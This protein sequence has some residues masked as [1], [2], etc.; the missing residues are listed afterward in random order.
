MLNLLRGINI[1]PGIVGFVRGALETA[2]VAAIGAVILYISD[3]KFSSEMW[4]VLIIWGLRTLE[5]LADNIDP[6]K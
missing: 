3:S 4:A 2:A 5:G 1:P 6:K